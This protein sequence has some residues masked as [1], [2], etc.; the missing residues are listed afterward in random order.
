MMYNLAHKVLIP[1]GTNTRHIHRSRIQ[2]LIGLFE[3]GQ[4]DVEDDAERNAMR[5]FVRQLERMASQKVFWTADEWSEFTPPRESFTPDEQD[6]FVLSLTTVLGSKP[7]VAGLHNAL[8]K[9]GL[10]EAITETRRADAK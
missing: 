5:A 10:Q 9:V 3:Q 1:P 2:E 8:R 6:L 4:Q 7:A